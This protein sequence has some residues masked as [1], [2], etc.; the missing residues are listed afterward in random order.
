MNNVIKDSTAHQC[1]TP[2]ICES[3]MRIPTA[4]NP[5]PTLSLAILLLFSL[6]AQD[7]KPVAP[8]SQPDS[9]PSPKPDDIESLK[10]DPPGDDV[11]ADVYPKDFE[12]PTPRAIEYFEARV[13][14][15]ARDGVS[16]AIL[17]ELQAKLARE[18]GDLALFE[19]AEVSLRNSLKIDPKS[20]RAKLGLAAVLCDRH[21][22]TE[23]L[24]WTKE[25]LAADP[26]N[27]DILAVH[28]DACLEAGRYEE[29]EQTYEKLR[30]RLKHAVTTVRL[31]RAAEMRGR[32]TEAES[33]INQAIQ[34]AR[35]LG[36]S[37]D[38]QAWYYFRAGEFYWSI[39]NLAKA[40]Q[41]FESALVLDPKHHD[42]TFGKGRIL[43]ANGKLEAGIEL[44][45]QAVAIGA[46]PHMLSVLGDLQSKAGRQDQSEAAYRR[47]LEV[48]RSQPE[49]ARELAFFLAD[50]GQELELAVSLARKD[51]ETRQ[52]VGAWDALAW[53][54]FKIGKLDEAD[55]AVRKALSQGTQDAR[56]LYHAGMI[57]AKLGRID[58]AR[59][60]LQAA[61]KLNPAF[62]FSQAE[63][64]RRTI[65]QLATPKVP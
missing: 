13:R 36:E 39:G 58:S 3:T 53:T 42:A 9:K 57:D 38:S 23:A 47:V 49:Y 18:S 64:A 11:K 40:L 8:P 22:F 33:L 48:A 24:Q 5:W 35:S 15:N 54:L 25:L 61:L 12:V 50:R 32:L 44:V 26:R 4:T 10:L 65:E 19:K 55:A 30:Q 21:K 16:L 2:P 52:D 46:E 29:A 7:P 1:P 34:E 31:A 28:G 43:A 37:D 41:A 60:R 14:A 20:A 59:E 63:I 27:S 6:A 17:G 56:M 51:L 62:S 45:K